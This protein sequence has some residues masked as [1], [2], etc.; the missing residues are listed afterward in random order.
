MNRSCIKSQIIYNLTR[1]EGIR[2]SQIGFIALSSCWGKIFKETR[3]KW[4]QDITR[5]L[6]ASLPVLQAKLITA[7][8]PVAKPPPA[9]PANDSQN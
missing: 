6:A 4:M 7:V 8:V 2:D 9:N 5:N 1:G 3:S